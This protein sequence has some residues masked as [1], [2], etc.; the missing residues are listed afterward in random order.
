[1]NGTAPGPAPSTSL[2][3][4][5]A[6]NQL[7]DGSA[8]PTNASVI[9]AKLRSRMAM[10]EEAQ[11][12]RSG[13]GITQAKRD[14][15]RKSTMPTWQAGRPG[16]VD[17][18]SSSPKQST[19][20]VASSHL[21]SAPGL[22]PAADIL[23]T[24][25]SPRKATSSPSLTNS[26]PSSPTQSPSRSPASLRKSRP[27]LDVESAQKDASIPA[28][29]P[30][31]VKSIVSDTS[32]IAAT[33]IF[34]IVLVDFDHALGPKVEFS[35]PAYLQHDFDLNSN[36]PFLALPDG[37]HAVGFAVFLIKWLPGAQRLKNAQR[38]TKTIRTSICS[39]HPSRKQRSLA[40]HVIDKSRQVNF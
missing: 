21:S 8:S 22:Q 33:V 12:A 3:K 29:S 4:V 16:S 38:E 5:D 17:L 18:S 19:G 2:A 39:V 6:S 20:V 7:E 35:H 13:T 24:N 25:Q 40:S 15:L 14:S 32:N 26:G 36:L 31:S 11:A 37:A 34:G 28:P 23:S 9:S 1:M 27:F 30:T 10:F